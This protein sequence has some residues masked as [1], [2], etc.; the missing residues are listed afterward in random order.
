MLLIAP[1]YRNM[2]ILFRIFFTLLL[3]PLIYLSS[4]ALFSQFIVPTDSSSLWATPSLSA[5]SP[6]DSP[7]SPRWI[8]MLDPLSS[9]H[10]KLLARAQISAD[11]RIAGRWIVRARNL[12]VADPGNWVLWGMLETKRGRIDEGLAAFDKAIS[13][14]PSRPA[15]Y[16]DAGLCLFDA[17]PSAPSEQRSLF[18]NLAQVYLALGLDLNHFLW[19]DPHV[20]LALASI[21]AEKGDTLN[22]VF[23]V[24]RIVL[25]PPV[26][27]AFAVRKLALCFSLGEHVEAISSWN[28][29]FL[30]EALSS[31]QIDIISAEL[32]KYSIPDFAYMLAD[33]DL[34]QGR[35]DSAQK[36]LSSLVVL[37]PHVPDYQI[38]LGDVYEKLGR[39]NDARLCYEKGLELSPA[40][41]EAKKK[42]IEYYKGKF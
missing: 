9:D 36:E 10:A 40:N 24:K 38:A 27:W 41:Q 4:G 13:L 34:V 20:C 42:V 5:Y 25:Q 3:L 19:Q 30:P 39:R 37:R 12:S 16:S 31:H 32:K 1:L 17:L 35:L 14:N 2:S 7:S 11:D 29:V 15:S 21:R 23:W 8:S 22:A 6:D 28:K 33:L 18:R 26:D